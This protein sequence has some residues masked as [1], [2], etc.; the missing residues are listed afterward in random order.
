MRSRSWVFTIIGLALLVLPAIAQDPED[1][2]R[3]VARISFMSGEV[4]IE[5][6]D[7]GE[8]MAAALNAPVLGNDR[9]STGANSRAEVQFENA[10][11]LRIGGGADLTV[12]Q[13]EANRYQMA[14]GR[15]TITFRILRAANTDMELDTPSL[16]V[17]P[18]K[19]GSYRISVSDAGD[20][21]ITARVGDVEV[22][23]PR[24]SQWV[25]GGQTLLAR[26]TA[27]D[28]EF[29]I[30]QAAGTDDWDRWNDSRDRLITGSPSQRYVP[31]G[32][33]GAEDLD[34]YGN[35]VNV[36]QYGYVWQP[37]VPV[38]W[39]PYRVGRWVWLDWYGWTWVSGD[40]WGWA[41]YHYGR[42]FNEPGFGW[43]W[44]PGALG[45]RH[46]WS[47]AL[48]AFFGF[49][50]GGVGFGFGNV[51]WVPLAPYEVLHPWWGRGFYGGPTYINRYVNIVNVNVTNIYRN[52]R[53]TN[54]FTAV[55]GGDFRS[56]RFSNFVRPS[57]GELSQ[58][59]F[60]R[61]PLPVTP[62]SAH[63]R[64]SDRQAA[65]IPRN[66][67]PARVF[68]YRQ[69]APVQR[70]PFGEQR[71]F[72]QG[73]GSVPNRPVETPSAVGNRSPG[74]TRFGAPAGQSA[75]APGSASAA[76]NETGGQ[77]FGESRVTPAP[78]TEPPAQRGWSRFGEP[79][80]GPRQSYTA[81]AP[82]ESPRNSAPAGNY[83]SNPGRGPEPLRVAPP[84]VRQRQDGAGRF[85]APGGGGSAGGFGAPRGGGGGSNGPRGG[86]GFSAP[87]APSSGERGSRSGDGNRGGHNR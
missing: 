43:C 31:P 7:S 71:G 67:A 51:G 57:A 45:V 38:G 13:L 26:G 20:S 29:Q 14:V 68:S 28:P 70:T 16:S 6:G 73:T 15:G 80:A 27:S 75:V 77:R 66:T 44:Y 8:W 41:P 39:A 49:G 54:G 9:I 25:Y 84:V 46:Y 5:R 59:S 83:Q 24:G 35:W 74:W 63:L 55:S 48:V 22:Y 52:S 50:G 3:G 21:E 47:P 32:V 58:A 33:Y 82:A 62:N 40:P 78:S 72:Q 17:R 19:L 64:Y 23:T 36:P 2:R 1:L 37:A 87:R 81:P 76:R 10:T 85:G 61:G 60:A 30:V 18:T 11:V 42:W 69:P 79:Y 53:V 56:G 12:T 4:S 86:G 65:S 34:P